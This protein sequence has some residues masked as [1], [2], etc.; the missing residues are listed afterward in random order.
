MALPLGKKEKNVIPDS[1]LKTI[2][3]YFPAFLSGL[4]LTASFPK[5]GCHWLAWVALIPLLVSTVSLGLK[6]SFYAGLL[7]GWVHFIT[8]IYWIVPTL[9][10][11]GGLPLFLAL[12][13]LVVFAVYLGLYTA[14]FSWAFR[15]FDLHNLPLVAACLW[16][17]L[18]YLRSMLF[19]GFPWGLVGYTQ[20]PMITL[21]Q[22]ADITGVY[23]LSFLIVFTNAVGARL[24]LMFRLKD[25]IVSRNEKKRIAFSL[26]L[27]GFLAVVVPGYGRMRLADIDQLSHGADKVSLSLIQGNISQALKWDE[28][29]KTKTVERYCTLSEKAAID[30]PDLIVWPET[31]L[32]FYYGWDKEASSG[33]NAC[34]QKAGVGFLIGSPA[35]DSDG[36]EYTFYNRAYMIDGSG[37]I[38]GRY[39]KI[40]LV[41]FGEY[42]PFGEALDFLGKLT[43]QAGN[44]SSGDPVPDPLDFSGTSAGVLICFEIIF[45]DLARDRVNSG[46]GILITITNDA[47]FG[48][49]SAAM[50]HFSMS[51]FRAVENRRA[52]ARAANTGISG[53][54]D[55][56]G[57]IREA[58]G[59][60]KTV[61][62]NGSM[63]CLTNKSF[64]TTH[65]NIF[66]LTCLGI[67]MVLLLAKRFIT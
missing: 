64:Y 23:G 2:S 38:T 35:L 49:T 40:H 52:V 17:V 22:I 59:L 61:I 30:A 31:A 11:Y 14:G 41:P 36:H 51:V 43:A 19:T 56:S 20:Y 63:P 55:P 32:P 25:R 60:F 39:D 53:F 7:T 67:F 58:S 24:W 26:L 5:T 33:V 65:G 12:P 18:E 4:L 21:I 29:N 34:I 15:R 8:L 13:V 37:E 42:V 54:I 47:W 66:S 10:L 50:Q 16:V 27:L 45:P 62:L 1:R 44:F 46:A 6:R 9:R 3:I 57:R 48:Y 28:L